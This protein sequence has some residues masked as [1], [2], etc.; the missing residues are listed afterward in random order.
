MDVFYGTAF[1]T[2]LSLGAVAA[3]AIIVKCEAA[4]VD[5]VVVQILKV[6]HYLLVGLDGFGIIC[7]TTSITIRFILATIAAIKND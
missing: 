3:N 5:H 2:A 4:N 6:T 1:F 7:A